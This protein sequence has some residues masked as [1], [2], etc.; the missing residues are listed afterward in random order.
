MRLSDETLRGKTVIG[1]DGQA[2]GEVSAIF[3][4]AE[5]WRV[6]SLQVRLRREVAD[7]LGASRSMFRAGKLEIAI[8]HVQSV[9]DALVLSVDVGMLRRTLPGEDEPAPSH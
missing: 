1:A 8:G 6:E 4:E 3:L 9:G 7:L 5:T 2:I